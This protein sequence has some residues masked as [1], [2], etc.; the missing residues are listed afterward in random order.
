MNVCAMMNGFDDED[1]L[2][3][4]DLCFSIADEHNLK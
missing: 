2:Y 3:R 1:D 4:F